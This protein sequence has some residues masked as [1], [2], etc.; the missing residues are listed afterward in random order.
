MA[1]L[2]VEPEMSGTPKRATRG[3]KA[4]YVFDVWL[5]DDVVGAHPAVLVTGRVRQA[6]ERL[7]NPT[8]FRC[9]R[10]QVAGSRFFRAHSAGKRLPAFWLVN[11]RGR[12]GR[13]DMGLTR[14]GALVVS[15]RVAN[16]LLQFR[17]RQ[18]TFRQYGGRRCRPTSA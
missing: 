18:A 16:V 5:G 14:D 4:R 6:L 13:S 17:V 2:V 8:G 10:A 9:T 15:E 7:P 3:E 1:F 11:V 12:A